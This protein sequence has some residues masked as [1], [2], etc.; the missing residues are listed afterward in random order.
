MNILR[1]LGF[2]LLWA[3]VLGSAQAAA[4]DEAWSLLNQGRAAEARALFEA[5]IAE[6]PQDV[7]AW[8][9]AAWACLGLDDLGCAQ[10]AI[11]GIQATGLPLEDFDRL[12]LLALRADKG[13]R[14]EAISAYRAWLEQHP[15]D[16]DTRLHF[17]QL[18]S[19]S[20]DDLEQADAQ[21]RQVL[22][23]QPRHRQATFDRVEVLRWLE[24]PA[25]ARALLDRWM[26]TF[27]QDQGATALLE[28]LPESREIPTPL[29]E[30]E[31]EPDVATA[32]GQAS[33]DAV[34]ARPEPEA[35]PRPRPDPTP[36][37]EAPTAPHPSTPAGPTT[38]VSET[39]GYESSGFHRNTVR[40]REAWSLG[41]RTGLELG[42]TWTYF[43]DDAAFIHRASLGGRLVRQLPA[44][45]E[46]RLDSLL[47]IQRDTR[48]S[49]QLEG[50]L[51]WTPEDAPLG[52]SVGAR[53]RELADNPRQMHD[54]GLFHLIGAGGLSVMALRDGFQVREIEAGGSVAP[55]R[56]AFLYGAGT[57][58]WFSDANHNRTLSTGLGYDLLS[59][60]SLASAHHLTVRYGI[61]AAD[62]RNES[63]DYWAPQDFL[64]HLPALEYAFRPSED[65]ALRIEG[66]PAVKA[67]GAADINLGVHAGWRTPTGT[68]IDAGALISGSGEWRTIAA[69]LQLGVPR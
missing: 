69:N 11:E 34:D 52:L 57:M 28:G 19:W 53:Q 49:L 5:R 14:D 8:A 61:W 42:P 22:E 41:P 68:R 60:P 62:Y 65:L 56:G 24:R 31:P 17:A 43:Y 16:T 21:L 15:E 46:L 48:A 33:A 4:L 63:V 7:H 54:L 18:L 25:A 23:A 12:R 9:G 39:W 6:D 44:A 29:P 37:L 27:P 13:R 26:V 51:A 10:A 45:L 30:P 58:G 50:V 67:S 36:E 47:H 35:A 66:G 55:L 64:V 1:W 20:P 59:A 3:V 2:P 32:P 40:L 38:I